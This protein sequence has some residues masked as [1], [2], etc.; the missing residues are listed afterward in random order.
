MHLMRL[1][2]LC[3]VANRCKDDISEIV[4]LKSPIRSKSSFFPI[5]VVMSKS[6]SLINAC[7]G[8][9]LRPSFIN[10]LSCCACAVVL[11]V[12]FCCRQGW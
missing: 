11:F 3:F 2:R 12:L 4:S 1:E 6:R 7:R 9:M 10:L 8:V 5:E